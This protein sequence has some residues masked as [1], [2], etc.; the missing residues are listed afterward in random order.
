MERQIGIGF[1]FLF[2]FSL[3]SYIFDS[4]FF[5]LLA[6]SFFYFYIKR[7]IT[8]KNVQKIS[9][10]IISLNR[11]LSSFHILVFTITAKIVSINVRIWNWYYIH[12]ISNL[13]SLRAFFY[14]WRRLRCAFFFCFFVLFSATI[15]PKTETNFSYFSYCVFTQNKSRKQPEKISLFCYFYSFAASIMFILAE[16]IIRNMI[17][18]FSRKKVPF[19]SSVSTEEI[20]ISQYLNTMQMHGA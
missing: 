1:Q 16:E 9:L 17:Y 11:S 15:Q 7:T 14:S 6:S 2:P 18:I 5:F 12:R 20:L 13:F 8:N 19:L 4:H 3:F 10:I